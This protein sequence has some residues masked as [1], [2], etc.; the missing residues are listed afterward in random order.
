MN[1]EKNLGADYLGE[2]RC[3]FTVWAPFTHKVE[4]KFVSPRESIV[5]LKRNEQGYHQAVIEE[6]E[7]ERGKLKVTVNI[8]GRNTPVELEYW[9]VEKG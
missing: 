9:Q 2:G 4:V 5:E 3:R 8:F 6:V 1:G 7:P